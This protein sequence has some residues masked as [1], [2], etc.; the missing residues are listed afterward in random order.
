VVD[1]QIQNV[2]NQL[3]PAKLDGVPRPDP[4]RNLMV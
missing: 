4:A 3:N 2:Y 1:G